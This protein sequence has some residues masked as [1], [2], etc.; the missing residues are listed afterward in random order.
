MIS[1]MTDSEK[2]YI[3]RILDLSTLLQERTVMLLGPRQAGKSSYIRFQ[4][5]LLIRS[6]LLL[7]TIST[8]RSTRGCSLPT[9][10]PV[11]PMRG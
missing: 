8:E 6:F 10:Y 4:L 9:I 5:E 2:Q 11:I 1:A 3:P 7:V